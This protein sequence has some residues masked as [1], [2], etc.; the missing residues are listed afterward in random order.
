[1]K[2]IT[3]KSPIFKWNDEP[4]S[5]ITR[6]LKKENPFLDIQDWIDRE[7]KRG[8]THCFIYS[9]TNSPAEIKCDEDYNVDDTPLFIRWKFVKIEEPDEPR[10]G[11]RLTKI[12]NI[13]NN[14]D[15][16]TKI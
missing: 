10:L 1:M 13:L 15:D 8:Y 6:I 9:I 3:V 7:S 5:V 12:S 4:Y 16:E 14:I 2:I 11:K